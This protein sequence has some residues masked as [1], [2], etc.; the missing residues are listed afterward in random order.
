MS[1]EEG[2]VGG[3]VT[4]ENNKNKMGEGGVWRLQAAMRHTQE[5]NAPTCGCGRDGGASCRA[6]WRAKVEWFA[7]P[8]ASIDASCEGIC[9][10][11]WKDGDMMCTRAP[12]PSGLTTPERSVP[13][14]AGMMAGR[15]VPRV[16]MGSDGDGGGAVSCCRQ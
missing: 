15:R 1:G 13:S 8:N 16:V 7:P 11:C 2:A 5:E 10:A 14:L 9:G 12:F 6:L 3:G 4:H